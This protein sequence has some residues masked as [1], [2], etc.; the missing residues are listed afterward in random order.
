M[1][2]P[3]ITSIAADSN[4]LLSAVVGKA[5]RRVFDIEPPIDVVTTEATI[6]EVE[7]YLPQFAEK[8]GLD[9]GE[10]EAALALL[11]VRRFSESDYISHKK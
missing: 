10:L 7:E 9:L 1:P 3:P 2:S 6:A 5:A 4:V 8:Y 11:P